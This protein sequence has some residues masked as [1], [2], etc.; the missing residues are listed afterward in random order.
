MPDNPALGNVASHCWQHDFQ[1]QHR[2]LLGNGQILARGPDNGFARRLLQ[3]NHPGSQAGTTKQ[4][5]APA[6][7]FGDHRQAPL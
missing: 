1:V 5:A 2:R 4:R 6:S 3:G 7:G